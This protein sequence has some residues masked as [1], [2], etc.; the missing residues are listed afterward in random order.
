MSKKAADVIL[1]VG[2]NGQLGRQLGLSL[3][4]LGQVVRCV[5]RQQGQPTSNHIK[6]A[7]LSCPD[8]IR[9]VVRAVRPNVIVNAA[10]YTAVDAAEKDSNTAF[11][12]NAVA[13]GILGE[14]AAA[15][16]AALIHFSTDYVFNG[17]GHAPWNEEDPP[18]PINVYGK[19]KREGEVAIRSTCDSH[20]ILRTSWL[21]GPF[22]N[23]FVTKIVASGAMNRVLRIV[24]D[25]IGAPTSTRF[26]GDVTARIIA[27]AHGHAASFL[28][29][30]G[31][32]VHVACDGE[33]SWCGFA[34]EI[35]ENAREFGVCQPL[36][37]AVP[38]SK[39]P[40]AAARPLNSRFATTRLV[41]R[42]GVAI[43]HWKQELRENLQE[44]FGM[45][46]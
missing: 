37:Q 46:R 32:I 5:R 44:I 4:C 20:L 41:N 45:M 34:V 30:R 15:I 31:G 26:V 14:E 23:N 11:A 35:F 39:Y 6:F 40:T 27:Q 12:I 42:Y 13:P 8:H 25:Q 1:L 19:S 22:G 16:D 9:A 21:Y 43:P 29:D 3:D 10:A 2:A 28:R 7:D 36:I 24:D 17:L 38:T 18:D 33:T